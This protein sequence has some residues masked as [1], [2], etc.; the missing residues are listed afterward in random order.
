MTDYELYHHGIKGQKWGVRRTAAQLGRRAAGAAKSAGKVLYK[1]AKSAG[2]AVRK[3]ASKAG[4]AAAT[5]IKQAHAEN[6]EKRYYKKLHKKK[7]SQMTDKE[8]K[9]LTKRVGVE[10]QLKGAKYEMRAQNARKFYNNVAKQPI[11]SFVDTFGVE[12]AKSIVKDMGKDSSGNKQETSSTGQKL[13]QKAIDKY[14]TF[15]IETV[16]TTEPAPQR[17]KKTVEKGTANSFN[18]PVTIRHGR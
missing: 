1:N 2:K 16:V 18:N 7:L 9:D 13:K 10:A 11:N 12:L 4:K 15:D 17:K 14:H 6:K 8:I 5:K 3:E